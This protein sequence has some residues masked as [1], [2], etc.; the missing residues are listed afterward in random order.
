MAAP[1]LPG[2]RMGTL[3]FPYKY[4][5]LV[6]LMV[7][8]TSSILVL[9]LS[10]T[11]TSEE[12]G[13]YISTTAVVMSEVFKLVGSLF[14]LGRESNRG[15]IDV[16]T[17][18][19][20]EISSNT[21]GTLKL[22]IPALL[23]TVQNNL[24]FIALSNLS[25]ATYQV[26]YQLKIL[27]TAIFS[28]TMLSKIIS[29]RQWLSL[30][31]LTVGVALVQMPTSKG[32]GEEEIE[33]STFTGNQFIGLIAVLSAC[34]SSGF[35]GVYFE[36][37]LKGTKQS[38]WLRNIQLSLFSIVLGLI[39]VYFNDGDAVMRDGFF[40]HYTGITWLAISLQ[41]FGGLIIAAV[42]KFADNI[43]KGFANSIS[44]ILTGA[45]S[46]LFIG[47]VQLSLFFFAG[48]LLVVVSTFMYGHPSSQPKAPNPLPNE[49]N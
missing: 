10:R 32:E 28:V 19:M 34:C 7:Q 40:Q 9:R 41:A 29:G 13:R 45:L 15:P 21:M 18:T 25:A 48:T 1:S 26:T 4:I 39:G 23:Y 43:L 47:D 11:W 14:L 12:G 16:I 36:K 24:L 30:L 44:I 42:I 33:D 35:A 22:G 49:G 27:T 8:T 38:L 3:F 37:I 46:F 6:L 5:A 31:L 2:I 17:Y 20:S